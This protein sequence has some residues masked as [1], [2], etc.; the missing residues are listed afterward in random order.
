M[1]T[2]FGIPAAKLAHA[3]YGAIRSRALVILRRRRKPEWGDPLQDHCPR[4]VYSE[5]CCE[6]RT[7]VIAANQRVDLVRYALA[8][9][10]QCPAA[11]RPAV[12]IIACDPASRNEFAARAQDWHALFAVGFELWL[13]DEPPAV[14]HL[15]N[16]CDSLAT[17]GSV[18]LSPAEAVFNRSG[19]YQDAFAKAEFLPGSSGH[20]SP[21]NPNLDDNDRV[22]IAAWHQRYAD[23]FGTVP[24]DPFRSKRFERNGHKEPNIAH[25]A[26]ITTERLPAVMAASGPFNVQKWLYQHKEAL[27]SIAARLLLTLGLPRHKSYLEVEYCF[28]I[29]SAG[30]FLAGAIV[31]P[32]SSISQISLLHPRDLHK[33]DLREFLCH[34]PKPGLDR[35]YGQ[36][37]LPEPPRGFVAFVPIEV[38]AATPPARQL[39]LIEECH[40]RQRFLSIKVRNLNPGIDSLKMLLGSFSADKVQLRDFMSQQVARPVAALW[41]QRPSCALPPGKSID[42]LIHH[43]GPTIAEPRVSIIVPLYGR[44]DFMRYQL[45]AFGR[46]PSLQDAE[47]IYVVDDPRLSDEIQRSAD[48]LYR[49]F[50]VPFTVIDSRSNQG[51]SGACNLGART[52]RS[53]LFLLMNSDVFPIEPGWLAPMIDALTD[54]VAAVGARLLYEDLAVQHVGMAVEPFGAWANLNIIT[55][56]GK[57]L[58]ESLLHLPDGRNL[59]AATAACLLV[60][61]A[62]FRAI[63][64]L[65]EQFAIGDFEDGDLCIRL[66]ASGKSIVVPANVRL[67]HLERQSIRTIGDA[68]WREMLTLYNC[69]LFNASLT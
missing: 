24:S 51:F 40:K 9:L 6:S 11:A 37:H 52:A 63:D 21:G 2:V 22:P 23:V 25:W 14:S 4:S 19:W 13:P 7:W 47:W 39:Q 36:F 26:P 57:G 32:F 49:L 45:D 44:W 30:Y 18:L 43:Y 20:W 12:V 34:V 54:E 59:A 56:P 15:V 62:D 53:T 8:D 69:W 61:A 10:S 60:R 42:N 64:G 67:Y 66:R 28:F 27:F 29:P 55:H 41:Q 33:I 50:G 31:D 38:V 68:Q 58:P 35:V 1:P 5:F 65:S 16:F 46:D 48:A 17:K 3:I